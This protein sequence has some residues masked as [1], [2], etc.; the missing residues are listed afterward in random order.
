MGNIKIKSVH[1][2]GDNYYYDSP[3]FTD[4]LNIIR[5]KNGSGKSTLCD[6]IYYAMGGDVYQFKRDS[7]TQHKEITTDTNNSRIS[8]DN[9]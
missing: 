9:Q 7:L 3:E 2:N 1:Y 8:K 5:G 6:L 4:G